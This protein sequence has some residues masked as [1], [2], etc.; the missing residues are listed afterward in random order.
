M[1]AFSP[2]APDWTGL[3][4]HAHEFCCPSCNA[5]SIEATAAWINRR[6][7]VLVDNRKRKWQ[8]FYHCHCGKVWWAWSN[9]RH[10]NQFAD[11]TEGKDENDLDYDSFFGYF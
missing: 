10:P 4:T 5:S 6:S 1:E 11:R 9:D 2:T 8:E 3:A 7:P